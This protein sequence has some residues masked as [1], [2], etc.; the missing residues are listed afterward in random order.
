MAF[1]EAEQAPH[2]SYYEEL[3]GQPEVDKVVD[4][5]EWI[6]LTKG[7]AAKNA[8]HNRLT[9]IHFHCLMFHVI[10]EYGDSDESQSGAAATASASANSWSHNAV[11]SLLSGSKVAAKQACGFDYK[12]ESRND[13]LERM[14]KFRMQHTLDEANNI[15][16]K[17]ESRESY[18]TFNASDPVVRFSR[19]RI[20]FYFTP[21]LVCKK[22]LKTVGLGDAISSNG[23]LYATST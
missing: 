15:M 3:Q 6:L 11:S 7:A 18:V 1:A 20:R 13:Q 9:R 4:I 16:L 10:A 14:L 2:A 21:V 23:L 5:M 19:G 12:D 22:P 17:V 8:P